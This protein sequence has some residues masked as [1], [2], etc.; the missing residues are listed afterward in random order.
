MKT[1]R[2]SLW[3]PV[4]FLWIPTV[5]ALAMGG[6]FF[7]TDFREMRRDE[8]IRYLEDLERFAEGIEPFGVQDFVWKKGEG[9]V[10]GDKS[11]ESVFPPDSTWKS[12]EPVDGTKR[13]LMW[14][15]R[16]TPKGLLVWK[17]STG[18]D[19]SLVYAAVSH[20]EK[21]NRTDMIL[22]VGIVVFFGLVFTTV[23]GVKFFM[24]YVQTRDDFMAAAAHDLTTPL[25]AMRFMIGRNDAEAM[26]LCERMVRLVTN[27]RDFMRLGGKRP[28]P[29][30]E[31]FD[32]VRA[33]E[34]A[35]S[36]FKEDY[37]DMFNGDDVAF[38]RGDGVAV[39]GPIEVTGDE[40]LT[41]QILWNIL[42]ND[43]KYAAPY[44]KVEVRVSQADGFVRIAFLDEGQG[45]SPREMRK[46]FDR[47]YRA[48]TV[49]VSGKGGFGIGLPTSLEFAE[50]MG[51]TL[52]V[53]PNEPAGCIFTLSL[54]CG[55]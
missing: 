25:A 21:S 44:G 41:V 14:G 5:V 26:T 55:A 29:A 52:T 17:R 11:W 7:A 54:P 42:G 53:R 46:A 35:Y 6:Y 50:A 19:D 10:S 20:I 1:G 49:L 45:M 40:T 18:E 22:I 2:S 39:S 32:I 30:V 15:R 33:Y 27:I 31:K 13:K 37:R 43:L 8:E 16:D 9:V 36:V 12:L 34:E 23:V 4:A 48:R 3:R 51:G 28:K 47:Y 24:D 38:V